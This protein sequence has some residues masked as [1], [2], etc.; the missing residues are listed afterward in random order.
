M[1][2]AT[3]TADFSGY[4]TSPAEA[5]AAFQG[6]GFRHLDYSFYDIIYPGS[7]FLTEHWKKEVLEAKNTAEQLGFDFVQAHAP[8][9]NPL[10]KNADHE[11][12]MKATL[13]SIEACGELQI[14]NLVLHLG[15]C[16]DFRYPDSRE[17]YF[18]VNAEF[19]KKLI[20]TMERYNINVCVENSAEGNMRGKYFLMTGQETADFADTVNHPLLHVCFDVGHSNMRGDI[21]IY[22]EL[23][24]VGQHLKAVHIQDNFGTYDEHIFPFLGSL[25]L[26]ACIQAL[27]DIG[28][29]GCFTFEA[30]NMFRAKPGWP[31]WKKNS[32]QVESRKLT[33][34]PLVL[35]RQAE[36]LFYQMGKWILEQYDCF[37]E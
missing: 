37:E 12:G 25:D 27:L 1:K 22:R 4:T 18:K 35:R 2:L 21:D 20:P 9:Y 36:A 8:G 13:R 3:T 16:D 26:D 10:D 15:F 30:D 34:P 23:C 6:T 11:A 14:S 28:Y 32:P 31:H 7:P 29:Q 19:C 33:A 24:D 17:A 5:V